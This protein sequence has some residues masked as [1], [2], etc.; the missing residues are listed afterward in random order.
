MVTIFK[1]EWAPVTAPMYALVEDLFLGGISAVFEARYPGIAFKAVLL[2]FGPLFALLMAYR[3]GLIKATENSKM[4]VV[5]STGG[6]SEQRPCRDRVCRSVE[7]S[8]F[9]VP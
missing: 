1:K 9:P 6:M 8:V 4:G 7:V 3:S 2:P 5:A